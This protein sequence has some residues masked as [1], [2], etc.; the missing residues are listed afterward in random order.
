MAELNILIS[1]G[2]ETPASTKMDRDAGKA[3][4]RYN[5]ASD[6]EMRDTLTTPAKTMAPRGAASSTNERA[7]GAEDRPLSGSNSGA[8]RVR[9][10]SSRANSRSGSS[11][12]DMLGVTQT[13][14]RGGTAGSDGQTLRT[15]AAP[16][17]KIIINSCDPRMQRAVSRTTTHNTIG[18]SDRDKDQ[19][20]DTPQTG[21]DVQTLPTA[22]TE[23]PN[24]QLV[25]VRSQ[26]TSRTS[27]NDTPPKKRNMFASNAR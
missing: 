1:T 15:T 27:I 13:T 11:A 12:E 9:S 21:S 16:S 8:S 3:A 25:P 4:E 7:N 6:E 23:G 5:I 17:D 2:Y 18:V 26:P 20:L 14:A 22:P 19:A 10:R 24:M